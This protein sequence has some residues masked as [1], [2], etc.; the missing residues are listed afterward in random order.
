MFGHETI[1]IAKIESVQICKTFTYCIKNES[2][3]WKSQ[4]RASSPRS[5]SKS[6]QNITTNLSHW[7][8]SQKTTVR[9]DILVLS[10]RNAAEN[11]S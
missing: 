8:S 1:Q 10:W 5:T 11:S 7:N 3:S 2:G 9:Y 6:R 4:A